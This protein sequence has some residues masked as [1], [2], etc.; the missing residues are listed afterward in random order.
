MATPLA[1]MQTRIAA[2]QEP[3]KPEGGEAGPNGSTFALKGGAPQ[4]GSTVWGPQ[5]YAHYISECVADSGVQTNSR[6]LAAALL[7]LGVYN[8]TKL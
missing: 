6:A 2:N 4:A 7:Q 5:G 1:R 8:Q 3:A